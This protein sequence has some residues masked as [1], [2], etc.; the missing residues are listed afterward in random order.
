MV[1]N[2]QLGV[3]EVLDRADRKHDLLARALC[4][5]DLPV[6]VVRV[7]LARS[8]LDPVP[9][10]AESDHLER[11]LEQFVQRRPWFE[12]ERLGLQRPEADAQ[13]GLA[14]RADRQR[15]PRAVQWLL[16]LRDARF[17]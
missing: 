3:A 12:A 7:K 10:R 16:A 14:S 17:E 5:L 1:R 13:H 15:L 9:V 11:Q 8:R 6:E 4:R 2:E